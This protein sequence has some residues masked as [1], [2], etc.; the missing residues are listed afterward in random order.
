[1]DDDVEDIFWSRNTIITF[2]AAAGPILE[3]HSVG[4]SDRK[5][6]NVFLSSS[7]LDLIPSITAT[8]RALLASPPSL[9]H[10]A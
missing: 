5:R 7:F 8:I 6:S 2:F 1:M 4:S 10:A 3:M 9:L